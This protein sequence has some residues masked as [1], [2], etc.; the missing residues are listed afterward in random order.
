MYACVLCVAGKMR[1][2][3]PKQRPPLDLSKFFVHYG[4]PEQDAVA[5]FDFLDD[6]STSESMESLEADGLMRRTRS[7]SQP[8]SREV[9]M[10]Q[11]Q[12]ASQPLSREVAMRQ[13]QQASQPLSREVAMRQTQ[14][15]SQ[16]QEAQSA[17]KS[18]RP[19][20]ESDFMKFRMPRGP[21]EEASASSH[22]LARRWHPNYYLGKDATDGIARRRLSEARGGGDGGGVRVPLGSTPPPPRRHKLRRRRKKPEVRDRGQGMEPAAPSRSDFALGGSGA[23]P[24]KVGRGPRG[25]K[26]GERVRVEWHD[27]QV[28]DAVSNT[29]SLSDSCCDTSSSSSPSPPTRSHTDLSHF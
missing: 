3:L 10:R 29:L 18:A 2:S 21:V 5:A 14:Q 17:T 23:A 28:G 9:A 22:L 26:G 24:H 20:S 15:A 27:I 8:L 25:R 19:L 11:T 4:Q 6:I 16:R 7:A 13:T 12:Q 1:F